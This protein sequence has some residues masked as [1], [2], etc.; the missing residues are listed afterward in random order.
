MT[1]FLSSTW[2]KSRMYK[3]V[4]GWNLVIWKN[5]E[6]FVTISAAMVLRYP[7]QRLRKEQ[8]N[9]AYYRGPKAA[10]P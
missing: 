10:K 4:E 9:G 1:R 2:A 7:S 5:A 6:T 8:P 3:S